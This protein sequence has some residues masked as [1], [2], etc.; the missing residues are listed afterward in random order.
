MP[1]ISPHK[2]HFLQTFEKLTATRG[3]L[4][5]FE[6]FLAL[7]AITISN[8][9]D[10]THA[11]NREAQYRQIIQRYRPNERA[12]FPQLL[13]DIV[14]EM[15]NDMPNYRDILG[16]LFHELNLQ[17]KR[18]GQIFTPQHI[19]NLMTSVLLGNFETAIKEQGYLKIYD[20]CC[21]GGSLLLG[22]VSALFKRGYNPC[23][24]AFFLTEDIDIRCVHVTYI[25]LSLAGVPAVVRHQDSLTNETLSNSWFT[26]VFVF[27]HWFSRL[28]KKI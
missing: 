16:D 9:V 2:L 17:D 24:Q 7:S 19:S 22:A 13:T 18:R 5:A 15:K 20:P 10:K 3:K 25:Q 27:D 23:K 1:D 12:L 14:L 8:A 11:E 21:G 28:G 26:P 6:D 4:T